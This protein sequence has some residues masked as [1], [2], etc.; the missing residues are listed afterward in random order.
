[1]RKLWI[2]L[3]AP[4]IV[5]TLAASPAGA[6]ASRGHAAAPVTASV[7]AGG[8]YDF[9]FTPAGQSS[10]SY[11]WVLAKH[12]V[13]QAAGGVSNGGY[14]G[15]WKYRAKAGKFVAT[16]TIPATCTFDG[17]GSPTDGFSGN[18]NCP[19]GSSGT[20]TAVKD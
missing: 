20:W 6:A 15:T 18:Y 7:R 3:A 1:M 16:Y 8:T 2:V 12:H 10:Y 14:T 19:T 11:A 17:S 13:L 9:T 5:A 4:A